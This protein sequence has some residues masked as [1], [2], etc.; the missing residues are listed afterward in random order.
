MAVPAT[1]PIVM[2]CLPSGNEGDWYHCMYE[3][4]GPAYWMT[5]GAPPS[6]ETVAF[7]NSSS[8]CEGVLPM[9]ATDVPWIVYYLPMISH[10]ISGVHTFKVHNERPKTRSRACELGKRLCCLVPWNLYADRPL[11]SQISE[12]IRM[13]VNDQ[14]KFS[15]HIPLGWWPVSRRSVWR[16]LEYIEYDKTHQMLAP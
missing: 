6:I 13:V 10:K 4:G 11:P 2:V 5:Y 3:G 16:V 7:W 12:G 15:G 9:N 8:G 14:R 1:W